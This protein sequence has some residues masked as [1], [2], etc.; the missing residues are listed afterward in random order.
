MAVLLRHGGSSAWGCCQLLGVR[1]VWW[2]KGDAWRCCIRDRER[3]DGE[4]KDRG[5]R[6]Q[7]GRI[8]RCRSGD[9]DLNVWYTR[10]MVTA[11]LESR[12]LAR[13][14]DTLTSCVECEG[15]AALRDWIGFLGN[16]QIGSKEIDLGAG[17]GRDDHSRLPFRRR[18][19][20]AQ[21]GMDSVRPTP[22]SPLS[23]PSRKHHVMGEA[24]GK[25]SQKDGVEGR[26]S[27]SLTTK[28]KDSLS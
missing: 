12:G 9:G 19:W 4:G 1:Y 10:K 14:Q 20:C 26:S 22:I 2:A 11:E 6:K 18:Y 8:G 24:K 5:R 23:P 7:T 17:L 16:W 15:A 27:S 21:N 25:A 3:G 13:M 28:K